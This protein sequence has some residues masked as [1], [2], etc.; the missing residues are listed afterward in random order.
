[1]SG[2]QGLVYKNLYC[3]CDKSNPVALTSQ[4]YGKE[5]A[6]NSISIISNY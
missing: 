6:Y 1:M 2:P 4:E 3:N 5:I